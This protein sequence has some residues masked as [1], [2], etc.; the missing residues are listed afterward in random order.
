MVKSARFS[1]IRMFCW[2]QAL[3]QDRLRTFITQS[4]VIRNTPIALG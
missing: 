2:R 3:N 4:G 1:A